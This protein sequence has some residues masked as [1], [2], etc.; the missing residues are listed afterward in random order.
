LQPFRKYQC[1]LYLVLVLGLAACAHYPL[2]ARLA[3]YDAKAGYRFSQFKANADNTDSLFICLAFSGGG[4]RA[5]ALSYGVLKRLATVEIEWE[6]KQKN[7]LDEV[8][9]ISSVSGGSF[10]AAYYALFRQRV[11]TEFP[12]K[13][14][15]RNIEGELI[16]LMFNPVNWIRLSSPYFSR[17][18]LTAELYDTTV[19]EEKTFAEL[20][21][22]RRRPFLVLN[23]T[24]LTLGE[25]FE[26]TQEQFDVLGADIAAYPVARGVAA[27]SAFP[28][29]L[30]PISLKN[31]PQPA[32]YERPK[33][34][35]SALKDYE[36]NRRRY[37][38]AKNQVTYEDKE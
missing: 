24:N 5:A 36:R 22:Q 18:D 37:Q 6:G 35:E 20:L 26:F 12:D 30:S 16:R 19:F 2:N 7:L 34:Y 4:T 27:S 23:A 28:F 14:L 31:Y 32:D 21:A 1:L 17:I 25:R 10:T 11:F 29:L 8:D 13:F 33:E 38:W 15:Y 9:C 3:R